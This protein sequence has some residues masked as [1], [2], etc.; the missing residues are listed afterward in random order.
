[1]GKKSRLKRERQGVPKPPQPPRRN[2]S[3]A[4]EHDWQASE[5]E[6][7]IGDYLNAGADRAFFRGQPVDYET[8]AKRFFEAGESQGFDRKGLLVALTVAMN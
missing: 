4:S 7:L 3:P 2:L 8:L 6:R 1:M 5:L